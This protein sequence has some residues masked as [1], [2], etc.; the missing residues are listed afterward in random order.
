MPSYDCEIRLAQ[1]S[2]TNSFS[3]FA[4]ADQSASDISKSD[5]W[6]SGSSRSMAVE[7]PREF[8]YAVKFILAIDFILK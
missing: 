8:W 7:R 4:L 2:V 1:D 6:F 3:F 5:T